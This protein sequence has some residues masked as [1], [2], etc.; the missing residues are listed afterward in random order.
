MNPLPV[1]A[2]ALIRARSLRRPIREEDDMPRPLDAEP[3]PDRAPAART[4]ATILS[5]TLVASAVSAA[6]E[7]DDGAIESPLG[8][9]P[10]P[11]HLLPEISGARAERAGEELFLAGGLHIA[12]QQCPDGGFGWPHADCS[13]TFYNITAPIQLGVLEAHRITADPAMIASAVAAG[14]FTLTFQFPNGDIRVSAFTPLFLERLSEVSGDPLYADFVV[15]FF[16][17][18]LAG[19]YGDTDLDTE[20]W[21]AEIEAIRTGNTINLRPWEFCL[22]I[23]TAARLGDPSQVASFEAALLRGLS[24]LDNSDPDVRSVNLGLAGAILGLAHAGLTSFPPIAAPLHSEIDGVSTLEELVD[25]LLA[26]QTVDGAWRR[27]ARLGE[28]P[29]GVESTQVTAYAV[30]ALARADHLSTTSYS[31]PILRAQAWLEDRAL[32][33][34]G[35]ENS[36]GGTENTEVEGEALWALA[37]SPAPSVLEVHTLGRSGLLLS[38]LLLG[39]L[40]VWFS[41]RP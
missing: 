20:G 9:V 16:A 12:S 21:I 24:T 1:E 10:L 32:A 4:L 22:T 17:E 40:G 25:V 8:P 35:F 34:G 5:I 30:L 14:D 19:T 29:V 7:Q 26:Y 23:D 37:A 28:P 15:Q 39:G 27:H 31:A 6:P 13:E 38:L 11:S 2:S 18:L 36:P 3:G 33:N 41:R